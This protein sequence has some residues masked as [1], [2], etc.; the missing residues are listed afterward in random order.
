MG[1]LVL[2]LELSRSYLM[3]DGGQWKYAWLELMGNACVSELPLHMEQLSQNWHGQ[4]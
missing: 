2:M 1:V 3:P 4:G